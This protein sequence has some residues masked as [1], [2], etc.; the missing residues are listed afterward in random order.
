MV[1][2]NICRFIGSR[3]TIEGCDIVL[4][5]VP[6]DGT[7]SFRSGSR[8]GPREIRAYSDEGMEDFSFFC[9]RGLDEIS[10]FDIGDLPLMVGNPGLMVREVKKSAL[11][12][13]VG[14]PEV[15]TEESHKTA[16]ELTLTNRRLLSIGG[17]HLITYPLFLA[18]K[19]IYPDF[20]VIQLDAHADLRERYAGDHLSHSSVM[21]LCLQEGLKKLVQYGV[22]S[23]TR[24]EYKLR[25][26]D[27]RIIPAASIAEM[28]SSLKEGEIVY[29]SVD[30]DFFDP[31]CMPGTGT[32]EAG[33]YFFNE[34]LDI[35]RMLK[36]KKVHFIGA[37]V[38]ELAPDID[39]TKASTVFAAKVIRETLLH[40]H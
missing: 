31:A 1:A 20:T 22:R 7:S 4:V 24:E 8:F 25:Q 3:P 15:T 17:E 23:G 11:E 28:E 10:F 21:K 6:Y 14:N 38:V 2:P 40:M 13:M 18:M 33:G 34:Y 29:L 30:L 19:D 27:H 37:D 32:P 12:L 35:L 36:G 16:Y 9:N 26:Q 39:S 5:G